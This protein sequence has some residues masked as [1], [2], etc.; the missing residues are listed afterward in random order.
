MVL[1]MDETTIYFEWRQIGCKSVD[2]WRML[3]Y[4][5]GGSMITSKF[6]FVTSFSDSLEETFLQLLKIFAFR[7]EWFTNKFAREGHALITS[8]NP[9]RNPFEN[10]VF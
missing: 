3:R 9:G 7:D 4:N 6:D 1:K 2:I 8:G 10:P 5:S